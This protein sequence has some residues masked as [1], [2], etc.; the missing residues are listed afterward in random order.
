MI[1]L[2]SIFVGYNHHLL[3]SLPPNT[4]LTFYQEVLDS[5]I[6]PNYASSEFT[7]PDRFFISSI[8]DVFSTIHWI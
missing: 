5:A 7:I 2:L 1:K 8:V 4:S 3:K 6:S